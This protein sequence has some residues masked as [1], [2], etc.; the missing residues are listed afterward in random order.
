MNK[1][2]KSRIVCRWHGG[3]KDLDRY[4]AFLTGEQNR[5]VNTASTT[6]NLYKFLDSLSDEQLLDVYDS[7][8]RQL[9][10]SGGAQ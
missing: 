1:L 9:F 7:Q 10:L 4:V 6:R 2:M 8:A 3:Y 5:L